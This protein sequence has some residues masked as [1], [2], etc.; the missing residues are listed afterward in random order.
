MVSKYVAYI[1]RRMVAS[2]IAIFAIVTINFI[3]FRVLPGNPIQLLFRNPRLTLEQIRTL[4]RQ[5]GLDRPLLDQF[6]I[7]LAN[8]MQGNLGISFFYK[9]SVT[10]VLIPRIINT[11]VLVLPATITAIL[12]GVLTGMIA[13]WRRA[14]KTDVVI[15]TTAMG[16]YSLP[17]FWLGGVLILLSIYYIKLPI[18]GM[19][20]YGVTYPDLTSY[21][22]DF[23]RHFILPYTTLTLVTYGEF[24]I[25][26][27]S[28]LIDVL[29]EDYIM[30]ARAQGI[31]TYRL[32]SRYALRNAML[33]TVSILAIN[34]G[35]VVAGAVLTETVFSWPGVGRLIYDAILN[36][37][38]PILQGAFIIVTI[39]VVL[40]NLIADIIYGYLDPRVRR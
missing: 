25:V 33:P 15:M 4:E 35:L 12:L 24:T 32:L 6:F 29:T 40:A 36:R 31:P 23:L 26:L 10:D 3:L 18:S 17:T 2:L 28:A 8:V 13:A 22:L 39:S 7:Y 1:L 38:Y 30:A 20:T 34:L 19:L 16:L 5:F 9:T 14:S 27:R 11:I 37:D 21:L